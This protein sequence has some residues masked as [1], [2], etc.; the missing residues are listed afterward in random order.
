TYDR[1][2]RH[3]IVQPVRAMNL[4]PERKALLAIE[5]DEICRYLTA[6]LARTEG[7]GATV[8]PYGFSRQHLYAGAHVETEQNRVKNVYGRMRGGEMQ[9]RPAKDTGEAAR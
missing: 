3:F 9:R 1:G 7:L 4:D 8:K 5:E 6:F 2:V